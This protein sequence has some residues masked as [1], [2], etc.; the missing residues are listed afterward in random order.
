M[1]N[2]IEQLK[3][4][5]KVQENYPLSQLTTFRIGGPAKYF[6]KVDSL[7]N[8]QAIL[9]LAKVNNLTYFII[10]GGSNLLVSDKGF[11]GLVIKL[12]FKELNFKDGTVIVSADMGLGFLIQQTLKNNLVG[13][14]FAAG[15]PGTIAGAVVGNAGAYGGSISEVVDKIEVLDENLAVKT[16]T[17]KDL[18]FSYRYSIL[19]EKQS[20]VLKVYLT[21]ARGDIDKAKA[22]VTH[23][24]MERL[25][26]QPNFPSA[27][28][29]F[30]NIPLTAELLDKIKA[31]GYDL[32]EKFVDYQKVPIAW[33]T[34]QLGIRGK[35]IGGAQ[36]SEVHGNYV[37]NKDNATAEEV[38]M[39]ISYI[40]QKIRAEFNIQ[41]VE[42][43]CYIGF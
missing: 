33:L 29:V 15:I 13:L 1:S 6:C 38:A 24:Q 40:K 25:N 23:Y 36:L 19:K 27:G 4:I 28:C 43:I 37:I 2:I 21:L 12:N 26:K 30:K 7:D 39:L 5:V 31:K 17:N 16:L 35:T 22:E 3:K 32:P 14:E 34:D 41:L 18:G 10:G 42:E 20:I 8:L 11:N 9:N